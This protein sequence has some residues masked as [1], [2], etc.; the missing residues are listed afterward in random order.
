[1][2]SIGRWMYRTAVG[3]LAW[4]L[5]HSTGWLGVIA[6]A[7][8][9]PTVLLSIVSGA[10]ADRM[11]FMRTIRMSQLLAAIVAA[12]LAALILTGY[13]SVHWLILTSVCLG[14]AEALGQPARMA[15]V[16]AMVTKRDLSSA[17]ALGSAAFNG[18]RIIGPAIAGGLILSF[19]TGLVILVCA[20]VF[21]LFYLQL[22]TIRID[23]PP[24]RA[25]AGG[26]L[27]RD[28]GSG[29]VYVFQ[30]EGI[31][32]VMILLAA[33]SFLIRPVIE[34]MPAISARIFDTGPEGLA[35]LLASIGLGALLAS[36]LIA[37]RGR[38]HGLTRLLIASM[39]VTGL[40]LMLS[41][42]FQNI[43]IASV[44]LAVMGAFML[45]GNV[46]AQTLVQNSVEQQY[47]AR[48]MSLFM[49][50][51]YGLPAIGA[52]IM[53]WIAAFAGLQ[54]TVGTGALLMLVFWVWAWPKRDAMRQHLEAE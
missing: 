34:L 38:M 31:R 35:I 30:H 46:S 3:W 47:R 40:S 11:G 5:T 29:I 20:I 37:R 52:L 22:E 27:W 28:I 9:I 48:V 10:L 50:F 19:G 4:D 39:V 6:F 44:F 13:V 41:M 8:L 1:M 23:E 32:F 2:S 51:A 26:S 36:L 53:G 42:Q 25:T 18:S 15:A 49:I 21:F 45:A 24:P 12:I 16:N 54:M 33:T 17:I 14:G 43:W 7:D